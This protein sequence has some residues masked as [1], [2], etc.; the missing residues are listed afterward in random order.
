MTMTSEDTT[1][2]FRRVRGN[3]DDSSTR[4]INEHTE[5]R[6]SESKH[7]D[8]ETRLF[9]PRSSS[10]S[11]DDPTSTKDDFTVEPVVGWLVVADGPGKGSSLT[12]GFGMNSIGR[13]PSSR[14]TIDFGDQE[15]SREN[16]ASVTYDRKNRKFYIQHGGG[17]NL[18]YVEDEP[19]LM[20]R[21]LTGRERITIGQTTLIFVPFCDESFDWTR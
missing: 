4:A 5:A 21:Q 18:T 16:H 9:R 3:A 12:L 17:A 10:A 19:V 13:V 2:V 8:P 6:F 15:I 7:D 11:V 1:R 20:P 14:L